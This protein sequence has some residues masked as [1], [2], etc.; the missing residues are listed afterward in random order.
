MFGK[1]VRF[2][3]TLYIRK[4]GPKWILNNYNTIQYNLS[5]GIATPMGPTSRRRLEFI[6]LRYLQ[7]YMLVTHLAIPLKEAL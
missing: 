6:A 3:Y 2:S 7:D 1:K 5:P 4:S